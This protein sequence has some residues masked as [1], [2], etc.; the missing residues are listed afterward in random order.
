M[1]TA[2]H[3]WMDPNKETHLWP[4]SNKKIY[5]AYNRIFGCKGHGWSNLQSMHINIAFGNDSDFRKLHSAIRL[6]LPLIP[7]LSASSPFV[8]EKSTQ[9]KSS[10]LGFYLQNQRKIPS[11]IGSAIPEYIES[12]AEYRKKILEPMF[13]DIAPLD[14][15][16]LLQEE[17]LNSRGA[18]PKFESGCIEIRLADVQETPAIDLSIAYFWIQVIKQLTDEKWIDLKESKDI[19]EKDLKKILEK[20]VVEGEDATIDFEPYL[21]IFGLKKPLLSLTYFFL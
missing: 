20:T 13:Q 19:S 10:R 16:N 4:H 9:K 5:E 3:P 18:I 21:N 15:D 14:Q 17:W 12:E 7:A 8:E 6:I 11:I 1:P 2:M